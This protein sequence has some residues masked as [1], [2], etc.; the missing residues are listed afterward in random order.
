MKNVC[1]LLFL[2]LI[3]GSVIGQKAVSNQ[4]IRPKL[5]VGVMVD[6]MRWDFIYRYQSRYGDGGFKR[7]LREGF[8]CENTFI[9]YAQT[10]TAAGHASVYT[11]SVPALNGMVGNEW[12]DRSLKREVY[13]V[14]DDS[15]KILG[16]TGKA[17]PM[18]PKNLIST[19]ITDEL[20]LATNFKSKVVGIAIKDRGSILPAGHAGDAAYW[21]EPNSGNFVSSTW[22]MSALPNWAVAFNQRRVVDS[23]YKMNW[24]LSHPLETYVQSDKDNPVYQ[25]N[26][27][28]RK[29][30]NNI[31]KNF[32]PISSTPWGNTLTLGFSKAALEA[33]EMGKDEVTDFLAISLSSPDYIGHSFGPN[34]VE[35]EDTYIKLDKEIADFLNYLDQKVGKG[36]YLFFMTADHGVA[37]VPSFLEANQ[38]PAKAMKPGKEAE[39]AT[40]AKFGLQRLVEASANYQ[41][42]LDKAYID[43][44]GKDYKVVKSFYIDQLNKNDNML[45]AFDNESISL[46]NLPDEYK[47]M[48]QNGYNKKLAGDVQLIYRPGYIFSYNAS[49]TTHGSMYP[50]D[51]HIPLLWMGWGVKQGLSYRKVY[52]SDIAGTI[53]AMLK[54]QM[55]SANIGTVIHELI[56]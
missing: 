15:V 48:F 46:I 54:I 19:T 23:F 45:L 56:K 29:L 35:I 22:Y 1:T 18:S 4:V 10:A 47:G 44:M 38:I 24:A 25:K 2:V 8:S 36:Q 6:Q 49:G 33:E 53:A 26:P 13:C 39:N 42:F 9:P 41:I 20:E 16:G 55:P 14:E 28:P 11:G 37:H 32:G 3:S 51:S 12:Y 52:M 7:I 17:E 5:V 27:F 34:S 50:Y 31:G 30:E 43:S 40:M 21:Y